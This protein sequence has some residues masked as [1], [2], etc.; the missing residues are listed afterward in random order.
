M[1]RS[2]RSS[3]PLL[4]AAFLFVVVGHSAWAQPLK[5]TRLNLLG[6]SCEI[7][8]YEGGST[9]AIDAA[10]A[11]IVEIDARM[12][13]NAADS[14]VSLV[15][16][17]A[18]QH[19]VRV[20]LDVFNVI[21]RGLEFSALGDGTFDITVAPLVKLWGIGTATAHIPQPEEIKRVLSIVG[22][23]NIELREKDSSILLKKRGMGIDLGSIAKGY[24]AD[25]AERV[26]GEHG[27]RSA[28][29]NLGGNVL[30]MGRK[31]DGTRW[32]IGIQNPDEP[33]GT[34]LGVVEIARGSVTTAGTYERF[35][36]SGGRRYFH[37]L[38]AKTGYPAWNGLAA[39]SI[40]APDSMAA[41]GYDTLVFTLGLEG[42]KKLVEST[43]GAIEAI[44]ITEKHEVYVTSGLRSSF[45]LSDSRFTIL[46]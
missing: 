13:I 12:T 40:V 6:T 34:H 7:T 32:R 26:L 14:E 16:E 45:T 33:R 21:K 44:F 29:I 8:V 17:A 39:V 46:K 11:R 30:T 9:S 2:I 27:V 4:A 42:G 41:D 15:N 18:G 24:A 3:R 10:F 1:G 5:R 38:N 28:L 31:P 25:E 23:G 36:E 22:Y 19:P 37:I 43:H 35:F 20:G